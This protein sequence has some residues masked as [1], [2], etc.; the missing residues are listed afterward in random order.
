MPLLCKN[1]RA[2]ST[3][4]AKNMAV[5]SS[6]APSRSKWWNS[7]PPGTHS[8][9][10]YR[11]LLSWYAP[12]SCTHRGWL[13]SSRIRRS[14]M[15]CSIC[16]LSTM[17]ALCISLS[18]YTSFDFTLRTRRTRPNCPVPMMR[19]NSRSS[20]LTFFSSPLEGPP[21][22]PPGR[23]LLRPP[24]TRSTFSVVKEMMTVPGVHAT[25]EA[26]REA[27]SGLLTASSLKTEP[28]S[29]R[30]RSCTVPRST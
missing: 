8:C 24:V 2:S 19:W 21:G 15:T 13:A 1:S 25:R 30:P 17:G 11:A 16:L 28:G 27:M 6:K 5:G 18:A 9:S 29:R 3:F 23:L 4:A 26:L 22:P 7:S 20:N 10:R 14:L 12:L